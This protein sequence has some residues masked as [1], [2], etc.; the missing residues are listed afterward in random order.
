[1]TPNAA[2]IDVGMASAEMIVAREL[3]RKIRTMM[4]A[5]KAPSTRCSFTA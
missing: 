1:M 4:A 3:P 5:K 2:M